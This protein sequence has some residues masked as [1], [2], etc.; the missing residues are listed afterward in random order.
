M[1]KSKTSPQTLVDLKKH[2]ELYSRSSYN[3]QNKYRAKLSI[4]E[5][6]KAIKLIKWTFQNLFGTA[7]NLERVSA[8][9]YL[10][11]H[12]GLNDG[13]SGVERPVS[14]QFKNGT[15][16]QIIHSLAK[17]KRMTLK[18]YGYEPHVG[19]YTDMNATRRD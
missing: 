7:L 12:S 3:E 2:Q 10:E 19:L 13:L 16:A 14:F 5:T 15:E 9:L 17:W 8:P 4:R 18:K 11:T 1:E 6:E